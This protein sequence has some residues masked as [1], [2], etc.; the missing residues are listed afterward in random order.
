MNRPEIKIIQSQQENIISDVNSSEA[1]Y[2]LYKYGFKK[3][4]PNN[5]RVNVDNG[6]TFEQMIA[7]ENQGKKV[8][9][10]VPKAVTFNSNDIGYYDSKYSDMDLDGQNF[11]IRIEIVTDMKF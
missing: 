11:G 8:K 2:L 10:E 1:D 6:M 7:L 4:V 3:E 9:K 5:P